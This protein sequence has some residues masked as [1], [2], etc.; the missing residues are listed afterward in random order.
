MISIDAEKRKYYK[1]FELPTEV[2]PKIGKAKYTNG[3]L[4]VVL[5]KIKAKK[6]AGESIKIE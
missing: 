3:V 4:E 6:S 1:E 2:N 5:T